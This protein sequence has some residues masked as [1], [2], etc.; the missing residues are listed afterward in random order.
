[1]TKLDKDAVEVLAASLRALA[2]SDEAGGGEGLLP[3]RALLDAIAADWSGALRLFELHAP[4]FLSEVCLG[5]CVCGGGGW[6]S[7][8]GAGGEVG[9]GEVGGGG[10]C[11]ARLSRS[12]H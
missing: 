7:T 3:P 11:R 12:S 8:G 6:S 1:V 10:H 9:L 5:V 4:A 2:G